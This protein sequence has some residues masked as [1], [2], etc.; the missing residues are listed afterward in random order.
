MCMIEGSTVDI[1]KLT[2]KI[3]K[4]LNI[5]PTGSFYF[6]SWIVKI[7]VDEYEDACEKVAPKPRVGLLRRR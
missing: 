2:N 6:S 5:G 4:R 7:V 1:E 3:R